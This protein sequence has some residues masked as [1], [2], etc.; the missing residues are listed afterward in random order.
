MQPVPGSALQINEPWRDV[1]VIE[2]ALLDA[3]W[4]L[5]AWD[6]QREEHR[7]CNFPGAPTHEAIACRQAFGDYSTHDRNEAHLL[8]EAPDR[9]E[10]MN[11]AAAKGYLHWMFRPVGGGVW[12]ATRDD[13]TLNEQGWRAP[14]CP[15]TPLAPLHGGRNARTVYRL[16]CVNSII[17]P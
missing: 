7:A 14:P 8:A 16:G 1:D 5:G 2:K 3:A 4:Q 10:M 9:E 12:Q 13:D 15:I 6:V 11:L 17:V